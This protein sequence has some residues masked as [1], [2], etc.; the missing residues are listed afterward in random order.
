M[1]ITT[2]QK[3]AIQQFVADFGFCQVRDVK[4]AQELKCAQ[5]RTKKHTHLAV[6]WDELGNAFVLTSNGQRKQM[7]HHEI[8]HCH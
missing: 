3:I 6:L 1:T 2:R 8:T 7:L 4:L 5:L